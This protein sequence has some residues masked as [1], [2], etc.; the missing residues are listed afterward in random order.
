MIY[1]IIGILGIFF[2]F[3]KI[4]E[5]A[6]DVMAHLYNITNKVWEKIFG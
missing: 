6:D 5:M 3:D 4:V 1:V 2:F